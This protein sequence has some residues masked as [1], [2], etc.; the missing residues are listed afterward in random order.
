MVTVVARGDEE[1]G[2][3]GGEEWSG[4]YGLGTNGADESVGGCTSS[5]RF[6]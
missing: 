3:E 4:I 6:P 2:E 5:Y 1:G